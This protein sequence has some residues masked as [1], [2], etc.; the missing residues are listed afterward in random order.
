MGLEGSL[1]DF[2]LADILQLIYFQKKTGIL[3]LSG[4]GDKVSLSFSEGNVVSAESRKRDEENRL[5]KVLVKKGLITDHDLRA[6]LAEQKAMGGRL[7]DILIA[8]GR[9][10]VDDIKTTLIS[11]VT[12]TV[13]QLFSWK[14]G[15]YEFQAQPILVSKEIPIALDTQHLLMDGLRVVDEW[16][17]IEGKLSLSSVLKR[18]GR[19]DASSTPEEQELLAHIDGENDVSMV[20]ELSGASDYE[21]SKALVSL[22]DRGIVEPVDVSEVLREPALTRAASEE[23]SRI[24]IALPVLLIASL[25]LSFA[26]PSWTG[27]DILSIPGLFGA[28]SLSALKAHRDVDGLRFSAEAYRYR[29]GSYPDTLTPIGG[30]VDT[31]GRPYQYKVGPDSVIIISAG[32]DG[33]FGTAD[34][35]F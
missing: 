32:P 14:E 29:T 22:L 12:E 4:R 3:K 33:V 15:T 24:L 25:L 20:I 8:K 17:V 26:L 31:W 2:G 16:S 18:T 21:A 7:G 9:V 5:G 28:S 35:V 23:R 27:K 13:I 1:I 6:A 19:D 10:T 34:D 11:Q 30:G